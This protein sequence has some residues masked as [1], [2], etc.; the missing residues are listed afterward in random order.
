MH[1]RCYLAL[2]SLMG[3]F[4]LVGCGGG[5]SG[6]GNGSLSGQN[7]VVGQLGVTYQGATLKPQVSTSANGVGVVGFAGASFTNITFNPDQNLSN[8]VVA[9]I[10]GQSVWTLTNGNAQL[11]TTN[12]EGSSHPTFSHNGQIAFTDGTHHL[13]ECNYDGSALRQIA[14]PSTAVPATPSWSPNNSKIAYLSEYSAPV[15]IYTCNATDG[16]ANTALIAGAYPAWTSDSSHILYVGS[17]NQVHLIPAGG[18]SNT[19]VSV[20]HVSNGDECENPTCSPDGLKYAFDYI[21]NSDGSYHIA[22]VDA[23]NLAFENDYDLSFNAASPFFS[24]DN[25][26]MVFE[27]SASGYPNQAIYTSTWDGYTPTVVYTEPPSSTYLTVPAPTWSPIYKAKQFVGSSDFFYTSAAGFL[28]SQVGDGFAS[29]VSFT[30]NTPT[31]ATLNAEP[32]AGGSAPLVFEVTAD[33]ITGF[34]YSNSYY[35]ALTGTI[36]STTGPAPEVVVS[37]SGTTGLVTST[38]VLTR[39]SQIRAAQS[40]AAVSRAGNVVTYRGQIRAINDAQGVNQAPSGATSV[41][42]D[43]TTGKVLSF[44]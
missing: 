6:A 12:A 8:S 24:P 7:A 18:G 4:V 43:T 17:D 23:N 26:Q 36:T 31:S 22:V 13:F 34:K 5:Q 41:S 15:T 20:N 21:K 14:L 35:G 1:F 37:F 3:A 32:S 33:S 42:L 9:F 11:I 25:K 38:I 2:V 19:V 28:C 16:S 39:T 30:A 29:M 10:S 27:G 40:R 44:Q